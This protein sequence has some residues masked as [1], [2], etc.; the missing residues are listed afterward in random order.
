MI[1]VLD[2]LYADDSYG[3]AVIMLTGGDPKRFP[4]RKMKYRINGVIYKQP[5]PAFIKAYEKEMMWVKLSGY[6]D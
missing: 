2:K 6:Y 1:E 3:W 5:T 4:F